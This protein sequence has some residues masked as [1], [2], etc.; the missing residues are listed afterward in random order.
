MSTV[1]LGGD[2]VHYEVLGRGRTV[3]L[4]HGWVGSWRYWVPVMQTLH[5][6][7][8]VF[9]VDL[10][11]FGDS[12]KNPRR[13]T[14][15]E[16]VR[17]LVQF[18]QSIQ[19]KKV[20]VVAHGLGAWVAAELARRAPDAVARMMLISS[21]LFDPGDLANRPTPKPVTHPIRLEDADKTIYNTERPPTEER[22]DAPLASIG[23]GGYP[24][25]APDRRVP[26]PDA[27]GSSD[28]TIPNARLINR[29][30]LE[31]AARALA[32]MRASDTTALKPNEDNPLYKRLSGLDPAGLL[33]RT[34]KRTDVQYEKLMQDVSRTDARVL[35]QMATYYD[36]GAALDAL[37]VASMPTMIV[38]GADDPLIDVPNESVWNYLT[39]EKEDSCVPVPLS[40]GHFPMFEYD[41]FPRLLGNF[42]DTADISNIEIKERWR[43][44]SR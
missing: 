36:A 15:D 33:N 28:P 30:R 20:A 26:D 21:P 17:M 8:R 1:T 43:R 12:A 29:A 11:G 10:F 22:G 23:R 42:L 35:I 24:E 37:R 25:D 7:Y 6:K 40:C 13:Y 19:Q 41:A 18:L 38:H 27:L 32:A 4:L 3:L 2:L 34:M 14:L 16:Q 44:R 39:N 9:A 31:E 5:L